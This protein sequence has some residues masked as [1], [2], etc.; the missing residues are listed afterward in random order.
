LKSAFLTIP[1]PSGG[2]RDIV[3]PRARQSDHYDAARGS[4]D[5]LPAYTELQAA[6]EQFAAREAWLAWIDRED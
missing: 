3:N 6:K 1:P 4:H 2:P 5:E